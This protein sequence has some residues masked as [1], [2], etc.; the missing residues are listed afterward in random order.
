MTAQRTAAAEKET[1]FGHLSIGDGLS[2]S[3]VYCIHQGKNGFMWFGTHDGLNKYDGYTFTVYTFEPGNPNSL[4]HVHLRAIAE[5]GAGILWL[6][7]GDGLD[8][9][10]PKTETFTHYRHDPGNPGSLSGN[11]IAALYY[12]EPPGILWIGTAREGLDKF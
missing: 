2:Q 9:F 8:R 5:D 1:G 11:N 7:T 3:S 6:G 10:D 12:D 4:S